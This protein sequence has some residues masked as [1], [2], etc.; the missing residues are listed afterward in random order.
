[1][2]LKSPFSRAYTVFDLETTGNKNPDIIQ[3]SAIKFDRYGREVA[4]FD[5]YIND[6]K[7]VGEKARQLTGLT[8]EFLRSAGSPS[9]EVMTGFRQFIGDDV[10]VGHNIYGSDIPKLTKVF[11]MYGLGEVMNDFMDTYRWAQHILSGVPSYSL[12]GL[13]SH[14]RMG[15]TRFHNALDDCY[16]TKCLMEYL[17]QNCPSEG[18]DILPKNK[19]EPKGVKE[20]PVIPP[21][22]L[23]FYIELMGNSAELSVNRWEPSLKRVV[24]LFPDIYFKSYTKM[25]RDG[26]AHRKSMVVVK[27]MKRDLRAFLDEFPGC[28]KVLKRYNRWVLVR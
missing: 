16:T 8:T 1:M 22:K 25:E 4:Q 20:R 7:P 26:T 17:L 11:Q 12:E 3:V 27:D 18:Y 10:L 23:A 21:D 14:L 28:V 9:I 19:P 15:Q 6:A 13:S 5:R 2:E 24:N